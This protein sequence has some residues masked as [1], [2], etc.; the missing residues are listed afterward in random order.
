MASNWSN[1]RHS[2]S[3]GVVQAPPAP[4]EQEQ[5]HRNS[6]AE[7][8]EQVPPDRVPG[9]LALVREL[10]RAR[11]ENGRPCSLP[12]K[13]RG[14]RRATEIGRRVRPKQDH[15]ARPVSP[16]ALGASCSRLLYSPCRS[17]APTSAARLGRYPFSPCPSFRASC[18]SVRPPRPISG[19]S[20][21]PLCVPEGT[22]S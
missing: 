12:A 4:D 2:R 3:L 14:P 22:E 9:F 10:E 19:L 17:R 20:S 5:G 1:S 6:Q 13:A 16:L 8:R 18:A 15:G 21:S 7:R 11:A